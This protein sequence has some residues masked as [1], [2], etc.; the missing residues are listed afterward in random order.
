MVAATAGAAPDVRVVALFEGRA[1]LLVDGRQHLL[2]EGETSPEGVTLLSASSEGA[3]L[4]IEGREVQAALD[5]RVSARK[6]TPPVREVQVRRNMT[7]MYATVGSING[8][9][10]P[11]LVDTGATQIAMNAAMARRLGIDY[12]VV[13]NP[14]AITTASG[15]ERG[16]HVMLDT[17]KLGE[18]E[19]RNVSGVVIEGR[20]PEVTLLGMSFLGRLEITN[21]G[22]LMT[23]RRKY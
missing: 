5:G 2:R 23:L 17:V 3:V 15:N 22:E 12:R 10:V 7:G 16:W 6:R 21:S 9:P 13:G 1:M 14:I 8:Y 4:E 11:F 18:I 20:Q 19:L